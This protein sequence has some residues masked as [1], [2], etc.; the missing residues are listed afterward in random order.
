L[1]KERLR[2]RNALEKNNTRVRPFDAVRR[3][4]L[5]VLKDRS[6]RDCVSSYCHDLTIRCRE[7]VKVMQKMARVDYTR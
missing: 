7:G 5:R 6:S 4:R 3:H 2:R 1:I